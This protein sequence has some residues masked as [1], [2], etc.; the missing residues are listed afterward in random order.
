[1]P[2]NFLINNSPI[3]QSGVGTSFSWIDQS[4]DVSAEAIPTVLGIEPPRYYTDWNSEYVPMASSVESA[5]RFIKELLPRHC[6]EAD[7]FFTKESGANTRYDFEPQ[8]YPSGLKGYPLHDYILWSGFQ[9]NIKVLGS[10]FKKDWDSRP[11]PN[12]GNKILWS[13]VKYDPGY[14]YSI[15]GAIKHPSGLLY[16]GRPNKEDFFQYLPRT[17]TYRHILPYFG[18]VERRS[19]SYTHHSGFVYTG[20]TTFTSGISDFTVGGSFPNGLPQPYG[21]FLD[22]SLGCVNGI[23]QSA[24]SLT[25]YSY[26]RNVYADINISA[27]EVYTM[28]LE[29]NS[30]TA[31]PYN[32]FVSSFYLFGSGLNK[33]FTMNHSLVS[34]TTYFL[35]DK[36]LHQSN[37]GRS[38]S[39][40]LYDEGYNTTCTPGWTTE[41]R[42]F[43]ADNMNNGNIFG[44]VFGGQEEVPIFYYPLY[45]LHQGQRYG[46]KFRT[47]TG[48]EEGLFN[49][50]HDKIVTLTSSGTFTPFSY[51][52]RPNPEST[53][54]TRKDDENILLNTNTIKIAYGYAQNASGLY[55]N[56]I[57]N[58]ITDICE[59]D[60]IQSY[61]ASGYIGN[62]V[63]NKSGINNLSQELLSCST[64]EN[65]LLGLYFYRGIPDYSGLKDNFAINKTYLIFKQY[66][67]VHVW[68]T[69][70]VGT[71][72]FETPW[73]N[74]YTPSSGNRVDIPFLVDSKVVFSGQNNWDTDSYMQMIGNSRI[75]ISGPKLMYSGDILNSGGYY[76]IFDGA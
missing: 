35:S 51:E 44:V 23:F 73:Y 13:G 49:F 15:N 40:I 42:I 3:T 14:N 24:I 19:F 36:C 52:T 64:S 61:Q 70:S 2:T 72:T 58:T 63:Y 59:F 46:N 32:E 25:N 16:Y 57:N 17:T 45:E 33:T 43:P 30:H 41:S 22:I 53:I 69:L 18:S 60:G 56:W 66:K 12:M 28:F 39:G 29:A 34:P 47:S 74:Q 8:Y 1:M 37:Y 26:T 62:I 7:V 21:P 76:Y 48:I 5:Q 71:V 4:L 9:N 38:I 54:I 20:E 10:G 68:N 67:Q 55:F 65:N 50:I 6:I 27:D 75:E 31:E 11:W